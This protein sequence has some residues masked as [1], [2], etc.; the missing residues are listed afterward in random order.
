MVADDVVSLSPSGTP[1]QYVF[2]IFNPVFLFILP[3][4]A[5]A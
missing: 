5:P 2:S 1:S 3:R 4:R